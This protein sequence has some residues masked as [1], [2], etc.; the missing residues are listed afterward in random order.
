MRWTLGATAQ[1]GEGGGGEGGGSFFRGK[2]M[3]AVDAG[4]DLEL[5]DEQFE[6][7]VG[8]SPFCISPFL[9][10]KP[11]TPKPNLNLTTK[12]QS[13][14]LF[15]SQF[16]ASTPFND[17]DVLFIGTRFSNLYSAVDTPA[18]AACVP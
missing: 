14:A 2:A 16:F 15:E 18:E 6:T 8:I 11:R 9:T 10:S 17:D 7:F 4:S 3:N 12:T 13:Q 1:C 5:T